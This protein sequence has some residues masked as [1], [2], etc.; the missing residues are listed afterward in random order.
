MPT[1]KPKT[2]M[3]TCTVCKTKFPRP[4]ARGPAPKYCSD[5]HRQVAF[6]D[7]NFV[8]RG[9]TVYL[10]QTPGAGNTAVFRTRKDAAALGFP[11]ISTK[12][13]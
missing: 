12:L 2:Q 9:D 8:K 11:V 1:A 6:I 10:S 5:A 3:L 4:N 13:R 7:R